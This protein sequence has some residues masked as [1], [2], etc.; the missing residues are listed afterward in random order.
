MTDHRNRKKWKC[1]SCI[2][3]PTFN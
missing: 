2:F 1:K 3:I